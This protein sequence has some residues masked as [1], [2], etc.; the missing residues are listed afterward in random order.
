MDQARTTEL[1]R[2]HMR[3]RPPIE[4]WR[5]VSSAATEPYGRKLYLYVLAAPVFVQHGYKGATIKALAHACHLSPSS[6]YHYFGSKRE[7]ATYPLTMLQLSWDNTWVDPDTDPLVQL[8]AMLGMAV[9]MFPIW[10]LALRLY[11]EIEGRLDDQVRAAGFRQGEAVFGRLVAAAAPA[12]ARGQAESL[13]RDILASLSGTAYAGLDE[14]IATAQRTRM[15]TV[16]RNGMVPQHIDA[17][18]FDGA[19]AEPTE[20]A[21]PG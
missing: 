5:M 11:E 7:M 14:D 4:P 10:A 3:Q 1:A 15:I 8:N 6:L 17:D 13:A 21:G 2:E 16:L 18:R 20:A 9:A 19:F 12:M